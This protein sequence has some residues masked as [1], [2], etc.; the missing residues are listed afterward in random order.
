MEDV[1]S[2]L[3]VAH[4]VLSR[5]QGRAQALPGRQGQLQDILRGRCGE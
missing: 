1:G 3:E 5:S 2:A 4:E